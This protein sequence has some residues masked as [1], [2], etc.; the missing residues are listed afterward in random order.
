MVDSTDFRSG[1]NENAASIIQSV[2]AEDAR[3]AELKNGLYQKQL[4]CVQCKDPVSDLRSRQKLKSLIGV[5]SAEL[6]LQQA[7]QK[8]TS[9]KAAGESK[10]RRRTLWG[11]LRIWRTENEAGG[12]FQQPVKRFFDTDV[13]CTPDSSAKPRDA[14]SGLPVLLR[15]IR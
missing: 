3:H 10:S 4:K 6:W 12:L 8:G 13:E 2:G 11:T 14:L 1:G 9:S 15:S 5:A 7:A